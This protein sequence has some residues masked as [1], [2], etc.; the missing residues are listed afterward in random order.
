MNLEFCHL[1]HLLAL[2]VVDEKHELCIALLLGDVTWEV[3]TYGTRASVLPKRSL[4]R[5]SLLL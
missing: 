1:D 5:S 4:G 3:S 2:G